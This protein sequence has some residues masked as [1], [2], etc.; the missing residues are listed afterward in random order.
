DLGMELDP[1]QVSIRGLE[2]CEWGRVGLRGGDETLGQ[3]RDRV[4]VAQPD[5]LV[6]VETLEQAVARVQLDARRPVFAVSRGEDVA[7]ELMCHE[8]C[9]VAD[10]QDGDP[11]GPDRWIGFRS[12]LVIHR[13]R[14]ARQDDRPGPPSPRGPVG[15]VWAEAGGCS[16]RA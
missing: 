11:A 1:V 13:R 4:A 7:T 14:A 3:P 9:A 12:A 15:G 8:L 2:A 16:V 10:A 6:T 5:R